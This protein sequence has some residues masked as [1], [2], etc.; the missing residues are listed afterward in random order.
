M[1]EMN[2]DGIFID[3]DIHTHACKSVQSEMSKLLNQFHSTFIQAT[4]SIYFSF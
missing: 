1:T 4:F 2:I 3:V